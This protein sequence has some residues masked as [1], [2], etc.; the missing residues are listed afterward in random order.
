M[1]DTSKVRLMIFMNDKIQYMK[2]ILLFIFLLSSVV[3]VAQQTDGSSTTTTDDQIRNASTAGSVTRAIVADAVQRNT[4]SKVNRAEVLIASGTD[5]YAITAN[6]TITYSA[7]PQFLVRFTNA[8]TGAATLNVTPQGGAA[9]GAVAIKKNVSTALVAGDILAGQELWLGYDGTNFQIIGASSSGGGGSTTL[10]SAHILV[11]NGSNVATD[12]AVSGDLSLINTGAFTV[13]KILGNTIPVN[14]SGVLTNNGSGTLTWTAAGGGGTVTSVAASVPSF[15]SV[16]GSPVTT[17]GTLAISY[18]GTALPVANGGTNA[19]SAGITAFNNITGYTAAGAT[20]TTSTNLVFSTSPT[21]VTPNLGTP[22][23]VTLTNGTGLPISTGVSGLGTGVATFLATPSSANFATAIT[24]EFGTGPVMLAYPATNA[25][26]SSYTLVLTDANKFVDVSNASANNL[27]VPTNASVAF[28]V[29]TTIT[30]TQTGAGLMTVVASGGVTVTTSSGVLTSPGQNS[31]MVLRK[32]GTDT[33]YLY[34]GTTAPTVTIGSVIFGG[35]A[36]TYSEDNSSLFFDDTNNRLGILTATPNST[37]V[38]NGSGSLKGGTV[39]TTVTL[40]ALDNRIFA[41]DA[42][43]SF[44]ITLPAVAGVID[45]EYLIKKTNISANTITI[46]GNG[47]ETIDG[48]ANITL[49]AQYS[50]YW[51]HALSTGWMI[52]GQN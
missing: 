23:A 28:A 52:I 35:S 49:T 11:G 39:T 48:S 17:S 38:N 51:I 21:L 1:S 15:L 29:G 14:A 12:V 6:S 9:L 31:P 40:G 19:T 7:S 25:Q 10:T 3:A 2:K 33:W 32:T 44:T 43:G 41:T 26:V 18:S 13:Q 47:A 24:D 46:D 22:S 8:N 5:T 16:A 42:A 27:T 45:R 34:N 4:D 37:F 30:L 50:F 36:G 20:G